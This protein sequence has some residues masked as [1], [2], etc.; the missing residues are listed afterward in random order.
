MIVTLRSGK[1]FFRQL[2]NG[3]AVVALL[4]AVMPMQRVAATLAPCDVSVAPASVLPGSQAVFN[5]TITNNDSQEDIRWI[6]FLRPSGNFEIVNGYS[7]FWGITPSSDEITFEGGSIA[8]GSSEVVQVEAIA[9]PVQAGAASW[10]VFI[11]DQSDGS[12][13]VGCSGSASTAITNQA[14]FGVTGVMA[15]AITPTSARI[16]WNSNRPSTS[17]VSYGKSTNYGQVL[18]VNDG[19]L[20]TQHSITIT[21][22]TQ[23]TTY[24]Y[25]VSGIEAGGQ[26]TSSSN[27]TFVTSV[28]PPP[29]PPS[30]ITGSTN[31]QTGTVPVVSLISNPF[32]KETPIEGTPPLITISTQLA[33]IYK[34]APT[35][36][37][38][39]TDNV[40]LALVEYSVDGG[41]NWLPADSMPGL[42]TPQVEF[43]F[44]P[45][46]LQDGNYDLT[47]RA[48]DSSKN[49][50]VK[51][52][53][54]IVIDKLPPI[55]GGNS[56]SVGSQSVLG[57]GSG[58]LHALAGVD[59]KVVM[60]AVGGATSLTIEAYVGKSESPV[61]TF[62]LS[63]SNTTGLWT[64]AL[65]FSEGGQYELKAKSVD[66]AENK[67]ER[68]I[69]AINV[70]KKGR[71]LDYKSKKAID[72][73]EV[74][75]YV[76]DQQ[77][78]SWLL[79]NA[80]SYG[81]N[82]PVKTEQDSGYGFY[83]PDGTFYL[84]VK[85]EGY[86]TATSQSFTLSKPQGI[87]SDMPLKRSPGFTIGS[88]RVQL[89]NFEITK[90]N[91]NNT[92]TQSKKK[93]EATKTVPVFDLATTRGSR[94]T[95]LDLYG[96]PSV[97]SLVSSWSP[98]SQEQLNIL[99]DL[100]K[101]YP[102]LKIVPISSG[103]SMSRLAAQSAIGG[104][105]IPVA[106]DSNNQL[107]NSLDSSSLPAHYFIDRRGMVSKQLNG[108]LSKE[109]LL[110][111]VTN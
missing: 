89:P 6:K 102:E 52:I 107:I 87:S 31:A 106:A 30:V 54:S 14:P 9:A 91:V 93:P 62:S 50:T 59:Q 8:P 22:L 45:K 111:N 77:T 88:T 97:I 82:N 60:S 40:S 105:G 39:A 29:P 1:R 67:T 100:A 53:G 3:L 37:G 109:E 90:I 44:T 57:D 76:K 84:Q 99:S 49:Q 73:A 4:I 26:S 96:S 63:K 64:G 48:T 75:V 16:T 70:Q 81:Q 61:Q 11:T 32:I 15:S 94:I 10:G 58:T 51:N 20:R 7:D 74:Y 66:G 38:V 36:S 12:D 55:V 103:E 80:Q 34:D 24:Y 108:V 47:V 95:T 35:I 42:G 69:G 68:I 78:G 21:N 19:V 98:G 83:L 13:S 56:M 27:N 43:S 41:Q 25:Q 23:G 79:W 72:G 65:R 85:K 17:K 101:E 86:F 5:F 18:E 92:L 110:Q 46:N 2:L 33:R 28:P 104:Y 71:I